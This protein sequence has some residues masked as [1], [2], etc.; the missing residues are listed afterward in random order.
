M[1]WLGK[2]RVGES[3]V[4]FSG[5]VGRLEAVVTPSYISGGDKIGTVCWQQRLDMSDKSLVRI[6]IDCILSVRKVFVDINTTVPRNLPG[7]RPSLHGATPTTT[8]HNM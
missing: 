8:L 3:G 4:P 2:A 5:V 1:E 6:Y 7:T